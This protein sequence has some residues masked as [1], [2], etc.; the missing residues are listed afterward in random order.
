M[1]KIECSLERD[2]RLRVL[3]VLEFQPG[4]MIL[5]DEPLEVSWQIGNG[6]P[7]VISKSKCV[8][9]VKAFASN[10][11]IVEHVIPNPCPPNVVEAQKPP[12]GPG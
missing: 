8:E 1:A 2:G 5:L 3:R 4:D 10:G 9:V 6:S 11:R 7:A 12:S